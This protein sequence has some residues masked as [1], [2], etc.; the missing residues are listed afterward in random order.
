MK[1]Y[2]IFKVLSFVL[3]LTS[4]TSYLFPTITI[5]NNSVSK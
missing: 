3:I 2:N 5:G 1:K 4:I